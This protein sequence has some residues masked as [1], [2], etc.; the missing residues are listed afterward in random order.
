MA[1]IVTGFNHS[2]APVEIREQ[3]TFDEESAQFLNHQLLEDEILQ[4]SVV[5][6]TCNRTEIYG[7]V[8][9]LTELNG[10]IPAC[11]SK[12]KLSENHI[13]AK[14]FYQKSEQ[15]AVSHLFRVSAGLDSMVVGEAQIFGQ[16]KQAY[17]RATKSSSTGVVLNRLFHHSFRAGKRVR[18]ETRVGEGSVSVASAGVDLARKIFQDISGKKVVLIGAGEM[19]VQTL[20]H[21]TGH[22]VKDIYLV[23]RTR[24]KAQALA[25]TFGGKVVPYSEL[26]FILSETDMV[27]ASTGA[28]KAI[29]QPEQIQTIM[30]YRRS[31]PLFF[32][33][34]SVPRNIHPEIKNIYNT[35]LYN[36]DDLQAI[37]NQNLGERRME[38]P[39][40]EKIIHEEVKEFLDWYQHRPSLDRIQMLQEHFESIRQKE[41]QRN[42][43][44]FNKE[45]WEQM[46]KFSKSLMKKFLHSPYMRLRSCTKSHHSGHCSIIDIFGLE[47]K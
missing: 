36:I 5:L 13:P 40:A 3:M 14:Y 19:A 10:Q 45:D 2:T 7:V 33:D 44:F 6:S 26:E 29:V 23:N 41:I 16:V 39:K 8:D 1:L 42:Q 4:E 18:S 32:I 15:D 9:N 21:L 24:E 47:D 38:I 43:K 35:Y 46:D 22:G 34:I 31:R 30:S 27:I 17:S 28:Q 11:L 20:T 12:V 37:V 25:E